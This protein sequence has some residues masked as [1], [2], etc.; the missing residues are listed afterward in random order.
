MNK[1]LRTLTIRKDAVYIEPKDV[2]HVATP[3]ETAILCTALCNIKTLG[4]VLSPIAVE[5]ASHL[6]KQEL[7]DWAADVVDVLRERVGSDV[8]YKP[9]YVNFPS[10]V[11]EADIVEL[12]I[13]AFVH[14]VSYGTLL[15]A[16]QKDARLPLVC[17]KDEVVLDLG[18]KE[19]YRQIMINLLNSKT[20][21]SAMDRRDLDGFFEEED[22]LAYM[23][24]V[25]PF[26]EN[27]AIVCAEVFLHAKSNRLRVLRH[28]LHTAT[29]VLRV[30]SILSGGTISL[31]GAMRCAHFNRAQRKF[32]MDLLSEMDNI[33]EDMF[34]YRQKWL[35]VGEVLHPFTYS[36]A[37][38]QKVV[39]AFD[40]LRNGKKPK[41]FNAKVEDAIACRDV[42]NAVALLVKR[43]GEFARR[44]DKLLRDNPDDVNL[45]IHTFASVAQC[46]DTPLLLE[47]RSRFLHRNAIKKRAYL[48]KNSTACMHMI[49]SELPLL[50][51][52]ICDRVAE[53][54][55]Q[56]LLHQFAMREPLGN[57]YI[58]ESLRGIVVPYSQRC[59]SETSRI[60]TRGS[61]L[62]FD[63][64]DT[65]RAFVWWTN[66]PNERVDIDLSAT[67]Y[68]TEWKYVSHVSFTHVRDKDMG[69]YHSG[70]I[71]SG[72]DVN[73]DGV[74]EFLDFDPQLVLSNGGRY[75]VFSLHCFTRQR[76]ADLPNAR[77]GWMAR[78]NPNSGEIFEPKTVEMK[79]DLTANDEEAMPV[80][81][82]CLERKFVWC[83]LNGHNAGIYN[84][85]E[86]EVR[87]FAEYCQAIVDGYRPDMYEL[88]ALHAAA[89]G[90]LVDTIE[91]ADVVFSLERMP[92]TEERQSVSAFDVDY[93]MANLL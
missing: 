51:Q 85:L 50:S 49:Y 55:K 87:S 80:F 83:D 57:V 43:P 92:Q 29:D 32:W 79:M 48:P 53:V 74:A 22:Y 34:R 3:E 60:L 15:P 37:R 31:W 86:Y 36:D 21:L 7:I 56:A 72:G 39:Q 41:F 35:R 75:V 52:D 47:L 33:V 58:E 40:L 9:M 62:P 84:M 70:D 66:M 4:F 25:I 63:V 18:T 6:D 30:I 28:Y 90:K 10:Q 27:V 45:I 71:V 44:L 19:D 68:D 13:N 76:F 64:A 67:V 1:Y 14:Y 5:M 77:F 26:K 78:S 38:Y 93:I 69:M 73:G 54:C 82:D 23:P 20:S 61:V 81:F 16:Y 91:E 2:S 65:V 89:R 59:A 24:E 11:A 12:Y 8:C 46:V 17:D 42:Q 88:A